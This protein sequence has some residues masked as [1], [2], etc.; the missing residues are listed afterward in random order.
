MEY[1]ANLSP[2]KLKSGVLVRKKAR[3]QILKIYGNPL[4]K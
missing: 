4:E 1:N 2:S 3:L